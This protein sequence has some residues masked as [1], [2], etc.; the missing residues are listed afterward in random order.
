MNQRERND[1]RTL[2]WFWSNETSWLAEKK[3]ANVRSDEWH[4]LDVR[5]KPMEMSLTLEWAHRCRETLEPIRVSSIKGG[6]VKRRTFFRMIEC[7]LPQNLEL[8]K[9]RCMQTFW[10]TV[11]FI[12]KRKKKLKDKTPFSPKKEKKCTMKK[13]SPFRIEDGP[14]IKGWLLFQFHTLVCLFF[15]II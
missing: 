13:K 2:A 14:K 6:L 8:R 5:Y 15:K 9:S 7:I 12:K 4:G 3:Q 11:F 1:T 10:K